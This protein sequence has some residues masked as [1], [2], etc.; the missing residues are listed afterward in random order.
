MGVLFIKNLGRHYG[1]AG[2]LKQVFRAGKICLGLILFWLKKEP[3]FETA[4]IKLRLS[5]SNV[6]EPGVNPGRLRHCNGYNSQCHCRKTG[7]RE[8]V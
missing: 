4:E 2:D 1:F 7:R 3:F 8:K 5:Q 6:W